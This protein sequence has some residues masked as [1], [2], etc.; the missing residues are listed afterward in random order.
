MPSAFEGAYDSA[1][2]AEGLTKGIL[3][4]LQLLRYRSHKIILGDEKE[5]IAKSTNV[6]GDEGCHL[7]THARRP[8]TVTLSAE[9]MIKLV[10]IKCGVSSS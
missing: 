6:D 7:F 4:L 10:R 5:Q 8:R 3:L 1:L 9:Q 2:K